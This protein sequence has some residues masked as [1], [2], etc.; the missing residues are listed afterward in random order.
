MEDGIIGPA[1][2]SH[3]L[4]KRSKEQEEEDEQDNELLSSNKKHRN[5]EGNEPADLKQSDVDNK[6]ESLY[7][8]ALLDTLNQ[9]R[10]VSYGPALPPDMMGS[11]QP[12]TTQGRIENVIIIGVDT[13]RYIYI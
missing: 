10:E 4:S 12:E 6:P 13:N 3:L 1:I 8:P 5:D 7:G 11:S 2:P 9:S